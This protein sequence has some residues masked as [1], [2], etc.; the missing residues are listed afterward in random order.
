M[1]IEEHEIYDRINKLIPTSEDSDYYPPVALDFALEAA[2]IWHSTMLPKPSLIIHEGDGLQTKWDLPEDVVRIK[3]IEKPYGRSLPQYI[4]SSEWTTHLSEDGPEI[5]FASAPGDGE[6][7]GIHYSG[8]WQLSDMSKNDRPA[9]T[10]LV[11]AWI[12][13]R[14]AAAMSDVID[15][16]IE[17]DTVNYADRSQGWIN[18]K[19]HF[20]TLYAQIKGLSAKSVRDGSPPIAFGKA[21]TPVSRRYTRW[22]WWTSSPEG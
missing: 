3:R 6:E 7:F 11:A 2:R 8:I 18:L 10:Y 14:R 22:W 9:I 19:N 20:I 17:A 15:P 4:G 12:S 13:M 21:S 16:L 5:I 1:A